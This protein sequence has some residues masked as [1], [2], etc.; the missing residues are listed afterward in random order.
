MVVE[1]NMLKRQAAISEVESIIKNKLVEFYEKL[2]KTGQPKAKSI[3]KC[4]IY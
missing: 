3:S 2:N 4:N 1:E